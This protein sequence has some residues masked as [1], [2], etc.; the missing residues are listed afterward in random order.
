[1][2]EI[3][4]EVA[5][6][7]D[8]VTKAVIIAPSK[9]GNA[10]DKAAGVLFEITPNEEIKCVIRSTNLD[11]FYLEVVDCISASGEDA[12]WRL[13]ASTMGDILKNI[14]ISPGRTIT[15]SH[16]NGAERVTAQSGRFKS[17]IGMIKADFY[18]D[19]NISDPDTFNSIRG[20]G[21]RIDM[22]A[23]ASAKAGSEPLSGIHF[24][25]THMVATDSYRVARVPFVMELDKPVTVPVGLLS[26]LLKRAGD[27]EVGS[28]DNLMV[29]RPDEYTQIAC[30]IF[31]LDYP[32]LKP[33]LE[34]KYDQTLKVNKQDF[35]DLI[36]SAIP[37]SAGDRSPLIRLFVGR[38]E[39]AVMLDSAEIMVGN[40]LEVP[41]ECQHPRISMYFT[42]QYLLDS[43]SRV[44]TD[45]VD[46]SYQE[47]NE[48]R[49]PLRID[50]GTEYQAWI[51]PRRPG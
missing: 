28:T 39:I 4:F 2:T 1:V 35:I 50:G 12:I 10:F 25:G 32:N 47:E 14:R 23:W 16:I 45:V 18:P 29:F 51:A 21:N 41:G 36:N 38:E 34:R 19:F 46:L 15:F 20:I 13:P 42:P 37:A 43:I 8:V 7:T 48:T 24:T 3:T 6:I 44:P 5:T 11:I 9:A 27:I 22:V 31:G 26:T 40:V 17:M 33:L 49:L 30:T